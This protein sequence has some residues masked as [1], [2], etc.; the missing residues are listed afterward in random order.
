MKIL[1]VHHHSGRFQLIYF[2]Y[3]KV[4]QTEKKIGKTNNAV[5]K[6]DLVNICRVLYPRIREYIRVSS[7]CGTFTKMD[8]VPTP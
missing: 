2:D 6:F 7:S 1:Q 5:Y 8:Q 4:K 3:L